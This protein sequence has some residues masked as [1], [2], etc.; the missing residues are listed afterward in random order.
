MRNL[1]SSILNKL[2]LLSFVSFSLMS[3]FTQAQQD[4]FRGN[5][6]Q[7]PIIHEDGR[8]SFQL[9]AP[10]ANNISISGSWMPASGLASGSEEMHKKNDSIWSYTTAKLAP[11]M[12][13]YSLNV[14]GVRTIDPS[15]AHAIRD[16]ANI[17]NV[18]IVPGE[19]SDLYR[20]KNVPHGTV[21]YRW[22]GSPTV[23]K[24]RR[25]AVYTPPGYENSDKEYPVLYLLHGIGGDEEAW[26]GSGRASEIMDNLIAENKAEPMIV[27]MPN[28]NVSQEASPGNGSAGMVQPSFMLPHTMDG[29]FEESF[30]DI[31]SFI[32]NNYRT[33]NMKEGRAIAGLSM[34]GF[35]TANI[36]L[37]YPNTF[38]YIGLFS[39]ALGVNPMGDT[40]SEMYQNK[41][42]KLRQQ[43]ENGYELYWLAIG[44]EDMEMIL[45]GNA[46]FRKKMDDMDMP[47]E[48]KETGG[49]H[50]WDNWRAYLSEFAQLLFK[51]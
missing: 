32:E 10:K 23:G 33:I 29:K 34:G 25:L 39:S 26:L 13:R 9:K 36:A 44:N 30:K 7:S 46:D 5:G 11:E 16:V 49:G 17:S 43:M 14:D 6:I 38:D 1:Y 31:L 50:T 18:F 48:Y 40:S 28:G 22:Y 15:N 19:K 27:V 47:Y 42:Q 4:I 2:R 3:L 37:N 12:Y 24:E 20:V 8:V 45:K 21:S 35:H 41:D 51:Q